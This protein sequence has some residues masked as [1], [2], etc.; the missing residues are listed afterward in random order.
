[1]ASGTIRS[2][3]PVIVAGAGLVGASLSLF[4][5]QRGVETLA[6][7]RLYD[8][9]PLP[10]AAHFHLRTLEIFRAAGI[11]EEIRQRSL[12]DFL[13]EGAIIAMDHLSGRKLAEIIPSL[14]EG[15]EALSPCRRLFITQPRLEKI[16]RDHASRSGAHRLD[17][18]EITSFAADDS[19]VRVTA[20]SVDSKVTR[21]FRCKY[22]IGA[23]GAHSTV[24]D[25]AGIKMVGR[26]V[27]SNSMTIYFEA[28]LRAQLHGKPWSV[29]YINN[30]VF[31]G[32]MR[33]S[34]DCMSGFVGVNR[35]GDPAVDPA[36][37]SNAAA[38]VSADRLVEIVRAAAGVA[39]LEVKIIGVARWRASTDVAERFQ[40]G[41]VF[42]A[43]DA[44][45]LM[46]PNGGFG[47]NTGIQDVHNL[48]WKLAMVLQGQARES[49]LMTYQRE[50]RPVAQ[51]TVE[52]A[53]TR[54]VTRTAPYLGKTDF[55]PLV[56]DFNIE[57]GYAYSGPA[58]IEDDAA[59]QLHA[60]PH[61]VCG[62]PGFRAPHMDLQYEG[63]TISTL[64]LFGKSYVLLAGG[65]GQHW[66]EAARSVATT[67]GVPIRCIVVDG[68]LDGESRFGAAYGVSADGAVLVR[69]DG[70]VAWRAKT[71]PE[72]FSTVLERAVESLV[73]H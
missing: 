55:Q 68:R 22:L 56:P 5:T 25:A 10:R 1:M 31:G 27:F 48:A 17:G 58:I 26:G 38:D 43:G 52:Q 19:G 63:Q 36:A 57:L 37:A 2:E 16:L 3:Y 64:D 45:H 28:D 42:L 53:Y 15:V 47:G 8:V 32:F 12:D 40:N 18:H 11:E 20:K 49:L 9:S 35:V 67:T 65:N 72:L 29:I 62:R 50:R 69:P 7:D 24:R 71:T 51:F 21:E 34:R 39:G 73:F 6:V 59:E 23:D 44:A 70:F 33:V 54:Y 13:P 46:P 14:N 41:R 30:P 60:D 66:P 61:T 4:L